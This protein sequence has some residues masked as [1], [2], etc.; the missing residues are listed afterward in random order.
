VGSGGQETCN[1]SEMAQDSTKV[2]MTD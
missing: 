1:I 2:T